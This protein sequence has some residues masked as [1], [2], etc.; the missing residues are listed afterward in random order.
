MDLHWECPGTAEHSERAE[1]KR[2]APSIRKS[3]P[4]WRRPLSAGASSHAPREGPAGKVGERIGRQHYE[5]NHQS[6]ADDEGQIT[7]QR[8]MPGELAHT[9]RITKRF[10]R[11]GGAAGK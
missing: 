6:H 5:R 9:W 8:C 10:D 4:R 7:T 3:R 2:R 11:N 1:E